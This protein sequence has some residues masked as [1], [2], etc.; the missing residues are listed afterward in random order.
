MAESESA[1]AAPEPVT[2]SMPV[3]ESQLAPGGAAPAAEQGSSELVE[4]HGETVRAERREAVRASPAARL[5]G[6]PDVLIGGAFVGGL[7]LAMI[8][9]RLAR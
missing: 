3:A 8:V 9:R 2:V 4:A 7:V 1:W 5:A 6:R